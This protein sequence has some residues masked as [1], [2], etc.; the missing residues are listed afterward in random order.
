MFFFFLFF[1]M[2]AALHCEPAPDAAAAA[3]STCP[4]ATISVLDDLGLLRIRIQSDCHKGEKIYATYDTI[5]YTSQFDKNGLAIFSIPI[6]ESQGNVLLRYQRDNA[7]DPGKLPFKSSTAGGAA[8]ITLQW[9]APVDLNLHVVEPGGEAG[10]GGDAA[11][12]PAGPA[13]PLLGKID[14]LDD[15]SGFGPFQESYVIASGMQPATLVAA[16]ENASRGRMPSGEH[17]EGGEHAL[18]LF[19]LVIMEKGKA[20]RRRYELSARPCGQPLNDQSY[21]QRVHF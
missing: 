9:E 8:R 4:A 20:R 17:C 21:F 15:G 12:G 7:G 6:V 1:G 10:K 18:V 3:P 13:K 16:V 19:S 11:V 2:P 14:L 5:E